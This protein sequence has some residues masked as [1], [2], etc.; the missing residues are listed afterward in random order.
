MIGKR[1]EVCWIHSG[2]SSAGKF[3]KH[4]LRLADILKSERAGFNQVV[5]M[6]RLRPPNK[7]SKSSISLRSAASRDTA[8]SKMSAVAIFFIRRNTF[9]IYRRRPSSGPWCRRVSSLPETIP[10]SPEPNTA[11]GSTGLP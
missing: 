7:P 5:M 11:L 4:F 1:R 2:S 6:G 8:A 9:L 3:Q 10:E